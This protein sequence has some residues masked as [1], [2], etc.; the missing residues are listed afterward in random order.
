MVRTPPEHDQPSKIVRRAL[1]GATF[2]FL[3][4]GLVVDDG[5]KLLA[6]SAA[7]GTVWLAFD[8]IVDYILTPL[9][10]G[11]QDM[12]L[13]GRSTGREDSTS[14]LP[15]DRRIRLLEQRLARRGPRR[16]QI[17][18][19]LRLAELYELQAGDRDGARLVIERMRQRY[20]GAPEL[21][22]WRGSSTST[23]RR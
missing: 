7:L 15:L 10:H 6:A 3:G 23:G 2:G 8:L 13:G 9:G 17:Q 16:R 22:D 14:A 21:E 4:F 1:A 12:L 18:D 20:P 19:A 11:I 5:G